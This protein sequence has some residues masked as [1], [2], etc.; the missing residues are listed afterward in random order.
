MPVFFKRIFY[1]ELPVSILPS[2]NCPGER[3]SKIVRFSPNIFWPKIY[4]LMICTSEKE[5]GEELSERKIAQRKNHLAKN[6]AVKMYQIKMK[7]KIVRRGIVRQRIVRRRIV[8][9]R[10]VRFS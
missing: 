10:I 7:Q 4:P 5:S 9:R 2:K 8:Q 6:C 3:F 1:Q